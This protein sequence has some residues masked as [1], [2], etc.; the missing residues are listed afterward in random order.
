MEIPAGEQLNYLRAA[1]LEDETLADTLTP[2]YIRI[3]IGTDQSDAIGDLSDKSISIKYK[4]HDDSDIDT[5]TD[6][7]REY[8]AQARALAETIRDAIHANAETAAEGGGD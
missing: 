1:L 2:A 5:T 8:S 7:K 3:K 4:L 6:A